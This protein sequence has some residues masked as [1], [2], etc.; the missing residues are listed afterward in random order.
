MNWKLDENH[1]LCLNEY[2]HFAMIYDV[3][4]VLQAI[5]T[6]VLLWYNESEYHQGR[7][8]H[9]LNIMGEIPDYEFIQNELENNIR[10]INGVEEIINIDF[11]IDSNREITANIIVKINGEAHNVNI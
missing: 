5:K 8:I 2:N 10:Q 1:D 7:G 9:Y 11:N 4:E 6:S 3:A